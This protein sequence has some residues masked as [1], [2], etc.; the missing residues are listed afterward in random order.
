MEIKLRTYGTNSA[1]AVMRILTIANVVKR[2]IDDKKMRLIRDIAIA[3][4]LTQDDILRIVAEYEI[5]LAQ[6]RDE[7]PFFNADR[8]LPQALVTCALD[9]IQGE[10]MQLQ[11]SQTMHGL[12]TISGSPKKEEVIFVENAVGYWGIGESWRNWLLNKPMPSAS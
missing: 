12:L 5:D 2:S 11:V 9:E 1:Y 6:V 7:G 3:Q 4:E 10:S 8:S